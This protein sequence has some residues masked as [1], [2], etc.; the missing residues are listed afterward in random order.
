MQVK[1]ILIKKIL[2]LNKI[3]GKSKNNN[4]NNKLIN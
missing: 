4:I 1:I 2:N 3:Y